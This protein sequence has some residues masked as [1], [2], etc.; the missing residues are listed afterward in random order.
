MKTQKR[1]LLALIIIILST[2]VVFAYQYRAAVREYITGLSRPTL[3][4]E[5]SPPEQTQATTVTT[6]TTI[7]KPAD[8]KVSTPAPLV[9]QASPSAQQVTT[10]A[11]SAVNLAIPFTSQAPHKNWAMPY[12]EAC[13]EA[14]VLMVDGYYKKTTYTTDSADAALLKIIAWE[15]KTFGTS[16]HTNTVQTARILSEYFGYKNVTV[17][18]NVTLEKIKEA[19]SNGHAVIV[20]TAGIQL[21]NP[22][23]KSPGP[24][25]HMLVI[26][27]YLEDGTFITN[28]PGTQYGKNYTY[29]G[30]VLLNAIHDY[31]NGDTEH[32]KKMMIIL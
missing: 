30:A 12:A 32:G 8:T 16:V 19:L 3:P 1:L 20:P 7:I 11:K 24:E 31:N 28:D 22:H 26:K 23:F 21:G 2:G 9:A 4:P 13:E 25:Y 14:S 18:E 6:T 27:G 17:S 10:V 15:E 5:E 29:S